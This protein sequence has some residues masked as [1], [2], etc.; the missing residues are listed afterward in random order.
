MPRS[1][2]RHALLGQAA[3]QG[4]EYGQAS[5][6]CGCLGM[7]GGHARALARVWCAP[8]CVRACGTRWCALSMLLLIAVHLRED[9]TGRTHCT[10]Q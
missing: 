8:W 6:A 2:C 10:T 7:D 9:T 5:A 1:C 4:R 3:Q